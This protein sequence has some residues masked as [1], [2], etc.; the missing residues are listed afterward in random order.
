MLN[1]YEDGHARLARVELTRRDAFER[2]AV[3]GIDGGG[4]RATRREDDWIEGVHVVETRT[5][6]DVFELVRAPSMD[7]NRARGVGGDAHERDVV[8]V[9][10]SWKSARPRDGAPR[11]SLCG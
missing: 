3:L 10:A 5:K 4:F 6:S 7:G 8:V 1:P 9:A 11:S 2:A